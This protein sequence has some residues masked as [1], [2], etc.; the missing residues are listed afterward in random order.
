[1]IIEFSEH[2]DNSIKQ[3]GL[4]AQRTLLN[5]IQDSFVKI[6]Y[7]P[8]TR[9]RKAEKKSKRKFIDKLRDY[10]FIR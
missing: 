1:M 5:G 9:H 4:A 8:K 7:R 6:D 2:N 10:L 3:F